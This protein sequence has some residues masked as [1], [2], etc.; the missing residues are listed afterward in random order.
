[1]TNFLFDAQDIAT[2]LMLVD[3]DDTLFQTHRRIV[4]QADFKMVTTDKQ[5][6]AL[7]YMN[8]IQQH[9]V[10]WLLHSTDL[11][12]VT[13]RSAEAL[14]RVHLPFHHGA[15][16]SHGG[17]VL[18]A[19]LGVNQAWHVQMQQALAPY[20]ARQ[21]ALMEVVQ[22]QAVHF[23]SIRTWM[24]EEQGLGLYVVAKQNTENDNPYAP[25]FLPEL[26][27]SLSPDVLDG[28][29]FHLNGNNLALIP[30]PVSKAN[31]ARFLLQQFASQQR[32]ILG[33]G[34]SLSDVE[35]LNLCHWWGMPNHSQ[36]NRWVKHNLTQQY[37][38][39]G[40]YGDYQ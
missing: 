30:K 36:L 33:F 12:P 23:G 4:P 14:S 29:Y 25:N 16:C 40:Y 37:K 3:L 24:V 22:Q 8:P 20:Q 9:F 10:Q 32:P 26:L 34:D 27:N 21:Q 31:A 39:E 35:F 38:Q 1:M 28:F 15:V 17:T 18:D 5:G 2:P 7:A 19:D 6:Q 13:A 11:I